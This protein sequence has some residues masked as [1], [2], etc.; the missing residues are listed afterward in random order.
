[1]VRLIPRRALSW[2]F[3]VFAAPLFVRAARAD[4]GMW[5]L[6]NPPN[7]L[8]KEHFQFEPNAAWLEH[9]RLSSVRFNDG[10]SGSFVSPSGLVLTNNHVAL[11]QLQKVSSKEKNFVRD[12]FLAA[13]QSSR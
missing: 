13:K 10:G 8:L 9:I 3:L 12:G 1:M 5:T 11:G 2:R 4:E 7:K 6:D